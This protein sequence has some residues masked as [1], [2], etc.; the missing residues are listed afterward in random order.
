MCYRNWFTLSLQQCPGAALSTE[1]QLWTHLAVRIGGRRG[2]ERWPGSFHFQTGITPVFL[3]LS[4]TQLLIL[5]N[6]KKNLSRAYSWF[7]L[8]SE[9]VAD[10]ILLNT[11]AC[12]LKS[13]CAFRETLIKLGR[14]HGENRNSMS[15]KGWLSVIKWDLRRRTW[16]ITDLF[17][18][19]TNSS[20][21]LWA[22]MP[23]H[24]LVGARC[25][26]SGKWVF[27]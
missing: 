4:G 7:K 1:E 5:K 16:I 9:P 19:S 26:G 22:P 15:Q 20:W 27:F 3:Y 14:W 6:H 23:L 11:L 25:N 21:G 12:I 24:A 2:G 17:L 18:Y 8:F 10:Y 13:I